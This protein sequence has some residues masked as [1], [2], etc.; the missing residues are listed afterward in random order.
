M[1][2]ESA[3][4]PAALTNMDEANA[5]AAAHAEAVAGMSDVEV[6]ELWRGV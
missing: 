5:A 6:R 3:T 1:W 2:H 4:A